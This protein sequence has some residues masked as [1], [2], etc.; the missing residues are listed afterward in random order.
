MNKKHFQFFITIYV[1]N[2]QKINYLCNKQKS[3][4]MTHIM[5]VVQKKNKTITINYLM[6]SVNIREA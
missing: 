4:I 3:N 2:I 5:N 1:A 6:V